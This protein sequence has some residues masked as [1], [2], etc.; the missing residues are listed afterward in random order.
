MDQHEAKNSTKYSK[1]EYWE[2]RYQEESS[3][4]EGEHEWFS[5]YETF[6]HLITSICAPKYT[7]KILVPGNGNSTLCSDLLSDYPG[8]TITGGDYSPT[9]IKDM[10]QRYE[11]H[12]AH[13]KWVVNDIRSIGVEDTYDLVLEKGV[14]DALVAGSKSPIASE[15]D[16]QCLL[17]VRDAVTSISKALNKHGRFLSISFASPWLR[18]P[19]LK[20][21]FDVQVQSFFSLYTGFEYYLYDCAPIREEEIDFHKYLKECVHIN[22]PVFM[23]ENDVS[24]IDLKVFD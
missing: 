10:S 20:G 5:S 9:V 22:K 11:K 17:D 12:R 19:L 23:E 1:Q 21:V 3:G 4:K 14:L 24:H 8:S 16:S 2:K 6:R 13:L 18:L 7:K 15:M